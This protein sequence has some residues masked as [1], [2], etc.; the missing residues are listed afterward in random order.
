MLGEESYPTESSTRGENF[1]NFTAKTQNLEG[2]PPPV[3]YCNYYCIY[4][5]P[6]NKV[7]MR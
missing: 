7:K 1:Y 3:S 5:L 6:L 2:E 4:T